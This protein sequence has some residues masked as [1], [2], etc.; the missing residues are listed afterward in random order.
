MQ[1]ADGLDVNGIWGS[2]IVKL[3]AF[4]TDG[5]LSVVLTYVKNTP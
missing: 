2:S 5:W 1:T 3:T 4:A